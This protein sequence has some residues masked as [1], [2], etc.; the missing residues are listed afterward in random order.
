MKS[1]PGTYSENMLKRMNEALAADST[2]TRSLYVRP[3]GQNSTAE[4]IGN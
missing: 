3:S 1:P 2:D 4:G